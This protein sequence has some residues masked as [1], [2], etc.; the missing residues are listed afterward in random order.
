MKKSFMNIICLIL[1]EM[2][3]IKNIYLVVMK[4]KIKYQKI[5]IH[6]QDN[7]QNTQNNKY[8]WSLL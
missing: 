8:D 4:I 2:M 1:Q 6:N 3:M 5:F 7:K